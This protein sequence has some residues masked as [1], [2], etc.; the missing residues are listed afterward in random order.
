MYIIVFEW[1]SAWVKNDS[2]TVCGGLSILE[3]VAIWD[4]KFSTCVNFTR[5]YDNIFH[6]DS[7]KLS[8]QKNT[9]W[10]ENTY[11][12]KRKKK[13]KKIVIEQEIRKIETLY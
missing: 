7:H 5:K 4:K 11:R 1:L 9:Y 13:K 10:A 3:N 8:E 6:N 12:T 2:G